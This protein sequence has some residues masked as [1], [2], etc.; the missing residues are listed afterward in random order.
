MI[1]KRRLALTVLLVAG[2]DCISKSVALVTLGERPHRI[3]GSLLS[4]HL[5]RNTGAAF[6]VA[7][8]RTILLSAFSLL[9]ATLIT[10]RASRFSHH[11][12]LLAAGLVVGGITGNLIDRILRAP[13]AFRGAVV[14]WIEVTHWPTFN[15][16]DSSIV[17]GAVLAAVLVLRN[18]PPVQPLTDYEMNDEM[19][20]ENE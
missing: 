10:R 1:L 20:N 17:I 2:I 7:T 18:I 9:A 3:L 5:V 6:S 11:G 19:D 12:W 16:A 4:L 8:N 14:D 15:L 13:G